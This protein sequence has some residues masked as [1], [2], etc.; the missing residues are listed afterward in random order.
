MSRVLGLPQVG[1][2]GAGLGEGLLGGLAQ[3]LGLLAQM[4]EELIQF[5]LHALA[6][7]RVHEGNQGGQGQLAA[8]GKGAG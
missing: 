1:E 4:G 8:A 7:A 2:L 3:R 6:H 5:G